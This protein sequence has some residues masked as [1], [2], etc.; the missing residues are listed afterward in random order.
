[1]ALFLINRY[2]GEKENKEINRK[3]NAETVLLELQKKAKIQKVVSEKL[4]L[5][6]EKKKKK[7]K[8][9]KDSKDEVAKLSVQTLP[10]IEKTG[11]VVEACQDVQKCETVSK[12]D[13]KEE[14]NNVISNTIS[15]ENP[16]D[17]LSQFKEGL[18]KKELGFQILGEDVE[19]HQTKVTRHLPEWITNRIIINDVKSELISTSDIQPNID[20]VLIQNLK[21]I[22]ITQLFPVQQKVIPYILRD[23]QRSIS[24]Q[25]FPPRDLCVSAPTGS[26]KTIAFALPIVQAL[27]QRVVPATRALVVSPTRELSAQ[28]YK[29]FV[30]LCR[31][32]QLKCILITAA[33][34][35]LL[36]EQRAL[37][38][39]GFLTALV[40]RKPPRMKLKTGLACPADI[41]VATPG[42][43]A[44]HLSQ[45]SAFSLDKLRFLVI[46]EADRMMEQIHQ[47]WLTLVE[48]KVYK[49][50]FKPL[51]QHLA[52]KRCSYINHICLQCH[53]ESN[54]GKRNLIQLQKLLFSA[55]LSA[56]PEKLQQLNL[57]QPRIVF[58]STYKKKTVLPHNIKQYMIH[59]TAGE[60]PL[61]TLNLVLNKTRVLC[62]AGSIETTR[63]LSMLIQMY[64]D[65]EGKKEF[66]C[67]EFASHLP[68]S[69]RGKVLK[70]FISGKIN[71]LV[72][73]DSMARGLDVPC[74][75]H[76]ILYD[77]P[78][79]IKTYIHRIGRTARAGATG[80]A[81]TLLRKQEIFHFKKMIADAGKCKVKT[82][83]IPKEST[84]KMVSI[85]EQVLPMVAE[86]MKTL[87]R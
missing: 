71:V 20:Q 30:S 37:L 60:K 22:G 43:L 17:P 26:G 1:M 7:R 52:L 32:T 5:S 46:D 78:P 4:T 48:Q 73:S 74:V 77:V 83:K 82:M 13:K 39:F 11:V 63:K 57:F 10:F 6:D 19:S 61:I 12:P 31:N 23:A 35:S 44:D 14:T 2:T 53:Q 70:D 45:T 49:D 72:C 36:Q 16:Y 58:I 67:T 79:L 85:Y 56:D 15:S 29:V 80:T 81:Y 40:R 64:A 86:K 21:D 25:L 27:L 84:Q 65:K 68:S 76:V 47:R 59:C 69:K 8:K 38:N 51:P 42:R 54:T 50:S 55:T 75:E 9:T 24:H 41:V 34:G 62:F 3:R 33:K 28:I 18:K 66:I 87:K